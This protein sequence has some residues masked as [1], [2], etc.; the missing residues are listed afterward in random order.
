MI[1]WGD[2][3]E[4]TGIQCSYIAATA[5][6]KMDYED[7]MK[8]EGLKI[9]KQPPGFTEISKIFSMAASKEK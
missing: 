6:S 3:W 1:P 2:D 9:L 5:G 7:A 8:G 4:Q